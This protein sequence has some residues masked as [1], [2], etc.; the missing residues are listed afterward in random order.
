MLAIVLA[1]C[2]SSTMVRAQESDLLTIDGVPV[3]NAVV[4]RDV[5]VRLRAE[6]QLTEDRQDLINDDINYARFPSSIY[7]G[8]IKFFQS[9]MASVSASYSSWKNRQGMNEGQYSWYARIPVTKTETTV[10]DK[11][12]GG[13][14][15]YLNFSYTR[16]QDDNTNDLVSS[17]DYWSAGF[18]KNFDSGVYASLL[19]RIS[20]ADGEISNHQLTEYVSWRYSDRLRIGEDAAASIDTETGDAGPWY[21]RL[22]GVYFLVENKTSLRM[23]VRYFKIPGSELDY[24]E[25]NSYLYQRLGSSTFV[26]LNYRFYHDNQGFES[27]AYGVKL[28]HYFSSRIA[29]HVAYRYY[30]H[31]E[32]TVFDTYYGGLEILL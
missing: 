1:L 3:E 11:F 22:F 9:D 24:K 8:E 12:E 2:L 10:Y 13:S 30:D 18:E 25:V 19:Y 29:A 20:R 4:D 23:D 21:A 16:R 32:D 15:S 17:R 27:S 6:V 26:R 7:W 5:A 14:A 28:Q 31:S